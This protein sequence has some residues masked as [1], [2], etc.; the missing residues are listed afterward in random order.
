MSDEKQT[1]RAVRLAEKWKA[2]QYDYQER[3]KATLCKITFASLL[4]TLG[5][6]FY[7][8]TIAKDSDGCEGSWV[9]WSLW[10]ILVMHGT[11][12][13]QQVCSITGFDNLFCSGICNLCLDLYEIAVLIFIMDQAIDSAHCMKNGETADEYYCLVVNCVI[14]WIFFVIS[15]FIKIHSFC[16]NKTK[17][18][19]EKEVE[20]EEKAAANKIN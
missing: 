12:I 20:N 15:W 16:D 19:L 9:Q 4:V 7:T 18:D 2:Q 13:V 3:H 10:L 14:Y 11:N 8:Y 6:A 17:E 1:H 5:L